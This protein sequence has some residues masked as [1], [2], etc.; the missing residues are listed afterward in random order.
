[1]L[2]PPLLA[3][4]GGQGQTRKSPLTYNAITAKETSKQDAVCEE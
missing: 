3:G 4:Y 1:M 2:L